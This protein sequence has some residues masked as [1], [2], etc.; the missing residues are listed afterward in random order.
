MSSS[1]NCRWVPAITV[2]P[3]PQSENSRGRSRHVAG[4]IFRTDDE[5][6]GRRI[7]R[8]LPFGEIG[9]QRLYRLA[10]DLDAFH[11]PTI[12]GRSANKNLSIDWLGH[13]GDDRFRR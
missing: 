9:T 3:L 10:I 6:L 7:Q 2:R 4:R 12:R 1:W 11:R 8:D 5:L 13:M